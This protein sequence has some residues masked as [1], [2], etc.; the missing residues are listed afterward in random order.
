MSDDLGG[1]RERI[2][3]IDASIVALLAERLAVCAEVAEVKARTGSAVI[4]PD[5]VREVLTSRRQWAIDRGVDADFAE[6]IFR[7]VL[8]ETH[9]I[10]VAIDSPAAPAKHAGTLA[11][12]LETLSVR[13][14]HLV[15]AVADLTAARTFLERLGFRVAAT[16]DVCVVTADAGGVTLV[17]VAPEFDPAVAAHLERHGSGIQHVAVEVLNAG[18]A[19]DALVAAGVPVATDVMVD[20]DGHEQVFTVRDDSTGVQIGFIGRTGHRVSVGAE[21]LRAL[22]RSLPT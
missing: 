16:D 18:L 17:V 9:R 19:R 20:A 12:A 2:D 7:T 5:R 13:I 3:E 1:L 10:E 15:L 21:N 11:G 6:Q 22:F 8:A 14:D 4:Q